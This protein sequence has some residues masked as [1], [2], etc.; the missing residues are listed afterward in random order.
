MNSGNSLP[1]IHAHDT[2]IFLYQ[3]SNGWAREYY[4]SECAHC[5]TIRRGMSVGD[6]SVA[7]MPGGKP[8]FP[9]YPQVHFSISHS[10]EY[11][12]AAFGGNPLGLDIQRHEERDILALAKRW[13]HNEEFVAVEQY[14]KECFFD[15]WSAK[16]SLVKCC[17]E[18][19]PASFTKFSVV[20]NGVVAAVCGIW[21]LKLLRIIAGY[22]FCL[23]A[24]EL[25]E[26]YIDEGFLKG[27]R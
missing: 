26:V 10:G 23:C 5:Y 18:G 24:K 8:Y 13:Y 17:G 12:A 7:S 14:G 2:L 22:S 15:I 9:Y 21:Q 3:N 11:W 6:F 16:E 1:K 4:L 27:C 25:G 20:E 19:F